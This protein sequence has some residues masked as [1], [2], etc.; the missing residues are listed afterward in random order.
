MASDRKR[1][2]AY[3]IKHISGLRYVFLKYTAPSIEELPEYSDIDMLVDVRQMYRI[4]EIVRA[5]G[6]INRIHIHQKSFV[7]F[8]SIFFEDQSYLELDLINRFDRKGLIFLDSDE[9]LRRS[10]QNA[11]MIRLPSK[12]HHFEYIM[13]F[14]LLNNSDADQ[15][16]HEHFATYTFEERAKIFGYIREKYG[17]VINTLDELF[18]YKNRRHLQALELI[19]LY[20]ENTGISR[21]KNR[22]RYVNDAMKDY[23]NHRGITITFSGVDGAGKSTV[24]EEVKNILQKKYRLKIVVI[25]HRPSILPILSAIR[26]GKKGAEERSKNNLPRQGKNKNVISSLFRFAY[27]YFDYIVGQFYVYVRYKLRGYTVLYDRYYFDFI[28]D[29]R[30]SNISLSRSFIKKGYH[31][32]FEPEVNFFLYAEPEIIRERKQEMEIQDIKKLNDDYRELFNELNSNNNKK[33]YIA[34]NNTDLRNTLSIVLNEYLN[35]S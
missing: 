32:I 9:V 11:E 13:L 12:E 3:F 35:V 7:T 33:R 1:F 14:Y 26:F 18:V 29:S 28:I 6:H 31:F 23:F 2:I 16:Y 15:K 34:I 25:R 21:L 19:R 4:L 30:R 8:V 20:P 17:Y 5:G 27:Y 24:L 10:S 22:F